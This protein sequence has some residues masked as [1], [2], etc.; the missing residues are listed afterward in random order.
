M[1]RRDGDAVTRRK[2][3]NKGQRLGISASPSLRVSDLRILLWDLDGTLV[4]GQRYGV[5]KDYTVPMLT[6]VFGTA[7][8]L[9]G[10]MVSGMTDLQ[11]IE[12]SLRG[13]GITREHIIARKDELL[14]CYIEEMKRATGNG[15]HLV[16]AIPGGREVLQRVAEHPRYVSALLTGNIEPAALFE[17]GIGRIVGILSTA[18]RFWR[19]VVRSSRPA[20]DCGAKNQ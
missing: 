14:S 20:G 17:I 16:E 9:D 11:I 6:R 1:I 18:G 2:K 8:S 13:E 5:F 3:R 19:F 12:E 10:M 15:A 7:G 4:R